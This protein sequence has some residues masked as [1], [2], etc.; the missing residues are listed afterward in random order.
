[1]NTTGKT[2]T[3]GRLGRR[4][5][6]V[7]AVLAMV[8][9]AAGCS[10]TDNDDSNG[11]GNTGNTGNSAGAPPV[12]RFASPNPGSVNTY[13]ISAPQGL[14]VIDTLRTLTDARRAV[15]EIR[16]SGQPVAAI[17][18]THSHPDHVGGAGV[19]HEAF[20]QAPVYASVTTDKIMREDPRGFYP[21]TRTVP[22]HDFPDQLTYA[23]RT[24]Q[25]G[26]AVDVAGL[27]LE[28]AEFA[29]GES[30]SATVFHDPAAKSLYAGDLVGNKVT[31]ALLE[32]HS[33][34]WLANLALLRERFPDVRTAYPGHGEPAEAV[35]MFGEQRGYIQDFRRLVGAAIA[36]ASPEGTAVGDG[37]RASILAAM[38]QKYP[39][40]PPVASLP[41]I[42]DENVKAVA[43]E[44][45]AENPAVL[46]AACATP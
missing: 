36:P 35:G 14:V 11:N 1:M 15:E 45:A 29:A 7:V 13:W 22:G 9:A 19:F 20:P 39:G 10:D 3:G 27:R 23:T 38:E 21:L 30:D 46:P 41:T 33:C 2:P 32:G 42:A 6:S 24:F 44:L 40:Y 25:A 31:P 8:V 4:V 16:R 43:A 28:T 12:G 18:L 5:A 17:L 37:E 26:E 34:G